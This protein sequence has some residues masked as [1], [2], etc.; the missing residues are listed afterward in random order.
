MKVGSKKFENKLERELNSCSIENQIPKISEDEIWMRLNTSVYTDI[1]DIYWISTKGRIFN[2]DTMDFAETKHR[3]PVVTSVPY[4]E[5]T[6]EILQNG[7]ILRKKYFVHRLMLMT[8]KPLDSVDEMKHLV[9]NHIDGNKINND[10][11]NLEWTDTRGNTLHALNTGLFVPVYGEKHVRATMTEATVKEIIQLLLSQKYDY[12]TIAHMVG[13]GVT[14][15]KVTDIANKHSWKHLT[16]G[17]DSS[18]LKRERTLPRVF[19]DNIID[20]CCKYFQNN[21]KPSELSVRQHCINALKY[22]SYNGEFGEGRLNSIRK[23]YEHE[24]FNDISEKYNF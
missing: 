3:D 2:E 11:D 17:I 20:E 7:K 14:T 19:T 1:R 8:F 10:I 13:K 22:S 23:L 18:Q 5:V 9:C 12:P 4:Y 16:M 15:S 6:L 21:P 24:R